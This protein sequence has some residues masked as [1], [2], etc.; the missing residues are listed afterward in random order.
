MR[1]ST[2]VLFYLDYAIYAVNKPHEI[3]SLFFL[4]I[5][6]ERRY[7]TIEGE[8]C[9]SLPVCPAAKNTAEITVFP[10]ISAVNR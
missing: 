8:T 2:D 10:Q 3:R 7:S 1:Y 6:Q 4:A 5:L 9:K